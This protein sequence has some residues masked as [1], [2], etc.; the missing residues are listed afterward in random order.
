MRLNA[1]SGAQ[2]FP[3][4][5]LVARH[6]GDHVS[7]HLLVLSAFRPRSI[8]Q[9]QSK[10]LSQCT[11]WC[12]VLSDERHLPCGRLK[13]SPSLNAPSGAQCFPTRRL[14]RRR[15]ARQRSQCTF[16][17]SVLSDKD[18]LCMTKMTYWSLN[19]PSGA[20]CF[21]TGCGGGRR[22]RSPVSMHLLVLSAFRLERMPWTCTSSMGLNAPS[23][24][25]CFPT[26]L[27]MGVKAALGGEVSMHL[28]V[29]SAFRRETIKRYTRYAHLVSMHLLVLSAFRPV[30]SGDDV[31]PS[32][33]VSMHLLVLSAF[34]PPGI[35]IVSTS[36]PPVSMHLLVLSAFRLRPQKTA[37]QRRL[38][39]RNRRR[40]GKHHIESA[41]TCPIKPHN[42]EK[43]PQNDPAPPTPPTR[44]YATDFQRT[45]AKKPTP[46][47]YARV[48]FVLLG[49]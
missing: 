6:G 40:P 11:F 31:E 27:D 42:R 21:P 48:N 15:R 25:Q 41:R 46:H 30:D 39:E 17:C 28:L 45:Q 23:G 35:S 2:C 20:Q 9:V 47:N 5:N 22:G 26:G 34:R 19:A 18:F 36:L 29:L 43:P 13:V 16:W 4:G 38:P 8:V 37:P 24:A 44:W 1:P 7:M 49:V 33:E 14:T 12:S 32:L 3:T 10:L